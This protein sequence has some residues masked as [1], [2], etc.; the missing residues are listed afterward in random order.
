MVILKY[1]CVLLNV[2]FDVYN[3]NKCYLKQY[4][5]IKGLMSLQYLN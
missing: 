1:F 4:F 2:H 3:Y 5:E